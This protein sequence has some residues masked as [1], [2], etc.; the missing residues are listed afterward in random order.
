MLST[1]YSCRILIKLEFLGVFLK[2][3]IYQILSKSIQ[4][5]L[6]S[7]MRTDGRT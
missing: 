4:W 5:E 2:E 6:S 7:F 3:L 1:R